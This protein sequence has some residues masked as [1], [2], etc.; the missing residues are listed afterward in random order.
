[1]KK[2]LKQKTFEEKY[3]VEEIVVMLLIWKNIKIKQ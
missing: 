3:A 1:V 2:I